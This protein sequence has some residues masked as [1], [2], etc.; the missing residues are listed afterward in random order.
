MPDEAPG[1]RWRAVRALDREVAHVASTSAVL[2]GQHLCSV[3]HHDGS[4]ADRVVAWAREGFAAGE[5]VVYVDSERDEFLHWLADDG[6]DY[7]PL[8]TD[9]SLVVL[10]PQDAYLVDGAY[11]L[12]RRIALQAAFVKQSVADGYP[13]V[14]MSSRA[15]VAVGAFPDIAALVEYETRFEA[16][17]KQLPMSGVCIYDRAA[18]V[19]ELAQV[20]ASHPRAVADDQVRCWIE[21]GRVRLAGEVDVS[22]ADLVADVLAHVAPVDGVLVLDA[23]AL[24]FIDV[25]GVSTFVAT[26]QRLA[27]AAR[28]DVRNPPSQFATILAA[29]AWEHEL[30]VTTGAPA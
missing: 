10:R 16:L 19:D 9:G 11:D 25:T 17:C 7:A 22:N 12:D 15:I 27:P 3:V 2:P 14:R 1:V 6:V 20:T 4:L 24:S 21:P 30:D 13:A 18:F 8:L 23:G 29:L 5:R 28:V 26:A